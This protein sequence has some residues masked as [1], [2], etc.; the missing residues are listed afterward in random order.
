[1]EQR[2]YVDKASTSIPFESII[3]SISTLDQ[4]WKKNNT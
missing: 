4:K 2:L 1:M 3:D